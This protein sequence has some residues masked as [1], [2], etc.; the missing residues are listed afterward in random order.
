MNK[1]EQYRLQNEQF[2]EEIRKEEGVKELNLN[3]LKKLKKK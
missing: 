3:L 1:R 2:L